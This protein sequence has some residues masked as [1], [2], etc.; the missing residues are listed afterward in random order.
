[1]TD[2]PTPQQVAEAKVFCLIPPHT[3]RVVLADDRALGPDG[4]WR[5]RGRHNW[6]SEP[7]ARAAL[8][9]AQ[10]RAG[11]N[12]RDPLW[13]CSCVHLIE[14][15]D[16]PSCPSNICLP[17]RHFD[18]LK[19][20][21][22]YSNDCRLCNRGVPTN[23]EQAELK[24][25]LALIDDGVPLKPA[26]AAPGGEGKDWTPLEHAVENC[27]GTVLYA[28][29]AAELEK[30]RRD[31]RAMDVLRQSK[32]NTVTEIERH[33]GGD[34]RVGVGSQWFTDPADALLAAEGRKD[35]K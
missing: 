19:F 31:G 15:D 5:E 20:W 13:A 33:I 4:A 8:A 3:W 14:V 27:E 30:L 11:V 21:W 6:P 9:A 10:E 2:S 23:A 17:I 7:A 22:A 25:M 1:M 29:A 32:T 34:F 26:P 12:A 35:G 28:E 16:A 24:N 18:G